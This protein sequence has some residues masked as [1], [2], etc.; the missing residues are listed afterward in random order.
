MKDTLTIA[1]DEARGE[2]TAE[3]DGYPLDVSYVRQGER[4][5]FTHTG[6]HPALRGRGLAGQMVE[7]ALHWAAPLALQVVPACSYVQVHMARHRRWQRLLEPAAVQQ[8]LNFWFGAVG[9]ADDGQIRR[10]W[11]VK[12]EAFD[13]EIRRRFGALIEKSLD[14]ELHD[15]LVRP[16]G[17]LA[18][19]LVLDQFT[20][21]AFRG[22]A[23]SFAGDPQALTIALEL[24]HSGV[25]LAPL[26]RWFALM[27]LEHAEDLA[28]QDRSVHEFEALAASDAR[29]KDALDYARRHREVIVRFG[30]YPH[31]NAILGRES[32]PEEIEFLKQPG[33]GF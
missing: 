16:Q 19:I 33:S 14:G 13:E 17:K 21:N 26:E 23:R 1:H 9:S 4:L 6:T 20:R 5:V 15:W 7:H 29:L 18:A 22:Q 31:R 30:R 24:L 27:P 12:D 10:Q 11:F 25:E 3:L 28:V 2:F 32:T 8:V